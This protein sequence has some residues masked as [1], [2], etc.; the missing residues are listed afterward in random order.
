MGQITVEITL[1]DPKRS[2]GQ[3]AADVRRFLAARGAFSRIVGA[4]IG[5]SIKDADKIKR[6]PSGYTR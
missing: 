4:A 6:E 5:M 3:L 2:D 1:S